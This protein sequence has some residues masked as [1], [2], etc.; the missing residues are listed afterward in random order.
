MATTII[1]PDTL[2][3]GEYVSFTCFHPTDQQVYEGKI[4]GIA[5]YDIAKNIE[6]DLIPYYREVA[7]VVTDLAPYS[8]LKYLVLQYSNGD[9]DQVLTIVR[10]CDWIDPASV[11]VID[12]DASFD[13]RIYNRK[14]DLDAQQVLD[15]LKSHGYTCSLLSD[16]E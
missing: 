4:V 11:T 12:P 13:I 15:L 6:A 7:K 8:T 1:S 9:P 10:A 16:T 2:K 14:E 3:V 5:S